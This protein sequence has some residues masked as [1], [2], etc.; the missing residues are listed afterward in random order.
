MRE[1]ESAIRIR[2]P[3]TALGAGTGKSLLQRFLEVTEIRI[4][5][6]NKSCR[7]NILFPLLMQLKK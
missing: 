1:R 3:P 7:P 4:M 6:R 2:G 5:Y